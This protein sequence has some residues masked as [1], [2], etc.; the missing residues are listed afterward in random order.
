MQ[1]GIRECLLSF[2]A[3]FFVISFLSKIIKIK[4][5]RTIIWLMFFMGVK[6][7]HLH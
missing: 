6:L 4:I 7:G 2:S 1:Y 3:E 5:Y